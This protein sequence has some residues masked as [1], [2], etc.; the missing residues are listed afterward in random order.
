MACSVA[1]QA[2]HQLLLGLWVGDVDGV[3]PYILKSIGRV[4]MPAIQ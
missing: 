3:S 1:M 4:E 2:V